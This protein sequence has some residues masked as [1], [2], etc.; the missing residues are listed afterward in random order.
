MAGVEVNGEV[1]GKIKVLHFDSGQSVK[2]G[3]LLVELDVDTDQA[4]LRGLQAELQLAN[5]QL[6]R[7]EKM[8]KKKYVSQADYDQQKAMLE[9]AQ[10]AVEAKRTRID[11]K[12][13]RAPFSGELGIRKVSLGWYLNEGDPIVSLQKLDPINLDFTLPERH[14]KQIANHQ[15]ISATVQAYPDQIFTGRIIA[16]DPAI[17]DNTRSVRVRARLDN[18][19]K[20]LR[21]GMFVEVRIDSNEAKPVLTLPDTAITYNPYGNS[22][23]LIE[24]REQNLIVQSRQVVTGQTRQ[25]RVEVVSGLKSGDQVVSAGQVKLRNGMPVRIDKL[26]AP[27]ER[28][29]QQ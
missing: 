11:K 18:P 13:I 5:T 25:G 20:R 14:L 23:F 15:Q 3:Q 12:Y 6:Q 4:E 22:V 17:E 9:Q 1:A 21:P 24:K 10:A 19:D 29:S 8:I 2:K 27:G 26:T 28:G 7:S 16:I